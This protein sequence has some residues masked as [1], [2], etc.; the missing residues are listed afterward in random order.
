MARRHLRGGARTLLADGVIL[1]RELPVRP[2]GGPGGHL[3]RLLPALR[4][5]RGGHV[6]AALRRQHADPRRGGRQPRVL[7]RLRP[8]NGALRAGVQPHPQRQDA[9]GG[10]QPRAHPH[11]HLRG[12]RPRRRG[13][14][15]DARA[16]ARQRRRGPLARPLRGG[17]ARRRGAPAR[18]QRPAPAGTA[19]RVRLVDGGAHDGT[20]HEGPRLPGRDR[21]PPRGVLHAAAH[22][23][24]VAPDARR[25]LLRERALRPLPRVGHRPPHTA[26]RHPARAGHGQGQGGSSSASPGWTRRS[27]TSR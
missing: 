18:H 15:A 5:V 11:D 23:R 6:A 1:R 2:A 19:A 26:L 7:R 22:R 12:R 25:P 17:A 3:L 27:S 4:L 8:R 24:H 14:R 10:L 16:R 13:R 9:R 21:A 20:P